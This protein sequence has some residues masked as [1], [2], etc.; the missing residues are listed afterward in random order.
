MDKGILVGCSL[1]AYVSV[2][3]AL[4]YPMRDSKL[5]LSSTA[6]VPGDPNA[7]VPPAGDQTSDGC[8]S[9]DSARLSGK[10]S[11]DEVK[12]VQRNRGRR[13]GKPDV[14]TP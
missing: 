11:F 7:V 14:D 6:G 13:Q 1:G 8:V 3:Y 12:A 4:K 5:V 10:A 2:A 9:V